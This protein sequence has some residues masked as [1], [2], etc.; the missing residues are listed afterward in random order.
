MLNFIAAAPLR[1][2]GP[3]SAIGIGRLEVQHFGE[4]GTICD[5]FWD[6]KDATVA[7]RQLGFNFAL[8]A[9]QGDDV[10]DGA[11]QIWMDNVECNGNE[12]GLST[13]PHN[14][15]GN[16]NCA[17]CEDAGVECSNISK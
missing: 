2:V 10:P 9:L 16:E 7:C 14:G 11:G 3:Q 5:D 15:W 4:W 8:R 1:I 6:L 12:N 13:C 17:H